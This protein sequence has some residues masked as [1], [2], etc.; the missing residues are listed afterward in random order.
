MGLFSPPLNAVAMP[1]VSDSLNKNDS[2]EFRGQIVSTMRY[3]IVSH[4]HHV[5]YAELFGNGIFYSL[6]YEYRV[7]SSM[8]IRIGSGIINSSNDKRHFTNLLLMGMI[9]PNQYGGGP[10]FGAGLIVVRERDADGSVSIG[11][12]GA[13]AIGYRYQPNDQGTLF[14][15][16]WTPYVYKRQSA[17]NQ[18]GN[19]YFRSLAGVSLGYA[20]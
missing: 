11:P 1:I 12:A 16:T 4:T 8:A 5:L 2:S 3:D 15:A 7:I 18:E 17:Y 6:N 19:S 20:F 10:E 9:I 14:R 13:L